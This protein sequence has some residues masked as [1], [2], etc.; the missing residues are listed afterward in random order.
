M[1]SS[2]EYDLVPEPIAWDESDD[3]NAEEFPTMKEGSFVIKGELIKDPFAPDSDEEEPVKP[4]V[5]KVED[6]PKKRG[7]KASNDKPNDKTKTKNKSNDKSKTKSKDATSKPKKSKI[8]SNHE[9]RD[10]LPTKSSLIPIQF[11][12]QLSET[13]S[14]SIIEELNN[15]N[16]YFKTAIETTDVLFES[17]DWI[18]TDKFMDELENFRVALKTHKIIMKGNVYALVRHMDEGVMLVENAVIKT[19]ACKCTF[20]TCSFNIS[21]KAEKKEGAKKL[22]EAEKLELFKE[23]YTESK[24]LPQSNTV[25]KEFKIGQFYAGAI[26]NKTLVTQI[27]DIVKEVDDK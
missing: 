18:Q 22:T 27:E 17:C 15:S 12:V 25:Y 9:Y 3:G 2:E 11:N 13:P 4:T 24:E 26:K 23:Y 6:E 7:R 5:L 10:N 19:S 20:T 21:I 16:N 8:K 14:E 1:S